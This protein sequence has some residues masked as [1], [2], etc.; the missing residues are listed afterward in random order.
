MVMGQ[1]SVFY[2]RMPVSGGVGKPLVYAV[3]LGSIGIILG[4]LWSLLWDFFLAAIIV[5]AEGR[6]GA[7]HALF[8]PTVGVAVSIVMI[9][10]APLWAM[11]GT[12]IGAGVFH[13]CL[14]IVGGAKKGFEATFRVVCYAHSPSALAIIPFCGTIVL[15]IWILVL[16]IIGASKAHGI[17]GWR[18]AVAALLP[19]LVCCGGGL[20]LFGAVVACFAAGVRPH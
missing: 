20:L 11:V 14:M 4:Q 1:P 7:P 10:L 9:V 2:E 17:S 13:L 12:F 6:A 18:A 15:G 5:G 8:G 19:M 16:E 3:I